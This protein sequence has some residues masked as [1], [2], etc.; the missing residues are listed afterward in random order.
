MDGGQPI[1][2]TPGNVTPHRVRQ[3]KAANVSQWQ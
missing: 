3:T 2:T 1:P